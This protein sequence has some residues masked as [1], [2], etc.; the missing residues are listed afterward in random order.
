MSL[1]LQNIFE[2]NAECIKIVSE[3]QTLRPW[4][5]SK[6]VHSE[7][8]CDWES[9]NPVLRHEISK[10]TSMWEISGTI[11]VNQVLQSIFEPLDTNSMQYKKEWRIMIYCTKPMLDIS[12]CSTT[13]WQKNYT[14]LGTHTFSIYPLFSDDL[15][16]K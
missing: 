13:I 4:T 1:K 15:T 11:T 9:D 2:F 16:Y 3:M 5:L 6:C 14:E 8:Y 10:E 12:T 7:L